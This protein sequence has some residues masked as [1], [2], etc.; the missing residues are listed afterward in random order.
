MTVRKS[1]LRIVMLLDIALTILM[2]GTPCAAADTTTGAPRAAAS[3]TGARTVV[4]LKTNLLYDAI[5]S[6]NLGLEVGLSGKLTLDVS[7]NLNLWPIDGHTWKHWQVQPELR[8]WLCQRFSGHF[9][10]LETHAGQFN[11]GDIDLGLSLLGTDFRKLRDNR[12][13]GWQFGGGLTYGYAWALSQHWN[14][15]AEIGLGYSHV[16]YDRY[17]CAR[18]GTRTR[19]NAHHNYYGV[20]KAQVAL[21]YVF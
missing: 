4:G 19:H 21:E 13:Q 14:L 7:G 1:Y 2:G 8:Y 6:P 11:A 17:L 5:L 20:T 15:E 18:C 16:I 3:A 10:G 9:L 12:Y